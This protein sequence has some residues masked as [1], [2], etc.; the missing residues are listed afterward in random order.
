MSNK[1][2]EVKLRKGLLI[3]NLTIMYS[4]ADDFLGFE[5]WYDAKFFGTMPNLKY[6]ETT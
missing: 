5:I 3:Y 1:L 2:T 4:F 6:I